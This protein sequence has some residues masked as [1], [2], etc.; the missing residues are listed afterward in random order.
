MTSPC[1]HRVYSCSTVLKPRLQGWVRAIAR[2]HKRA[3][4]RES[5]EE[6][7]TREEGETRRRANAEAMREARARESREE[8]E[9]RRRANA[10]AMREARARRIAVPEVLLFTPQRTHKST[11]STCSFNKSYPTFLFYIRSS[12]L[13]Y[14]RMYICLFGT[15]IE[16]FVSYTNKQKKK[17]LRRAK[18]AQLSLVPSLPRVRFFIL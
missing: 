8:G 10:E 6:R 17:K 12:V 18:R 7:E 11:V 1:L 3:L 16:N 5:P 2:L 4:A 15:Y 9:T 14:V 13:V